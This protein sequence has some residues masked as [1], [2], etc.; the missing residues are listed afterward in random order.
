MKLVGVCVCVCVCARVCARRARA[1]VC[2]CVCVCACVCV[3]VCVCVRVRVCVCVCACVCVCVR[4]RVRACTCVRVAPGE[5]CIFRI[6][7]V[8][9]IPLANTTIGGRLTTRSTVGLLLQDYLPKSPLRN[10][11]WQSWIH[12][13]H[14]GMEEDSEDFV[15]KLYAG[16]APCGT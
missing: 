8:W 5:R 2:V 10:S 16:M 3:C 6:E 11:R 1:R 9:R 7:D 14:C 13:R 12:G 4:V 15:L